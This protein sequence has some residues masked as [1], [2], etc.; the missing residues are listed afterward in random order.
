MSGLSRT[1]SLAVLLFYNS[2]L[3]SAELSVATAL[4]KTTIISKI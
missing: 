4:F 3:L 2:C 1:N